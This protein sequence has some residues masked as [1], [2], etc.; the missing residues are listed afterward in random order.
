MIDT[1]ADFIKKYSYHLL[2]LIV[3]GILVWLGLQCCMYFYPCFLL[4]T[5]A[6]ELNKDS[7]KIVGGIIAFL[8]GY[9]KYKEIKE[10][11]QN[12]FIKIKASAKVEDGY[13]F[14]DTE[15]KNNL[16]DKKKVKHAFLLIND[17][18]AENDFLANWHQFF[19]QKGF[20]FEN[21]ES[22]NDLIRTRKFDS[23]LSNGNQAY[24]PLPFYY[25]ENVR[26]GNENICYRAHLKLA[27]SVPRDSPK[28]YHIR[29]FVFSVEG[30][31]HR[32]THTAVLLTGFE[33]P[34]IAG[35]QTSPFKKTKNEK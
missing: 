32:T 23:I 30:H 27:N 35:K 33:L 17:E 12:E 9:M 24:I 25:K 31:L 3:I 14:I 20:I 6:E 2:W 5:W 11:E 13:L 16:N 4:S 26:I 10:N 28:L 22:T 19:M 29:L 1:V 34:I 18:A 15:V 7:L 21:P 8:F